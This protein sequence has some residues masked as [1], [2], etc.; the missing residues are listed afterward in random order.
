LIVTL[1]WG[2]QLKPPKVIDFPA[3][4]QVHF[5]ALNL[6]ISNRHIMAINITQ[7]IQRHS[8]AEHIKNLA[9]S[10]EGSYPDFFTEYFG[11]GKRMG[12]NICPDIIK[13]A[14]FLF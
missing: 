2:D 3:I 11:K 14:R 7:S 13:Y 8:P 5:D 9:L 12:P 10:L 6:S 1:H 4:G